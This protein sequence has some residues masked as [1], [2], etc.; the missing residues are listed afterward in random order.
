MLTLKCPEHV[1]WPSNLNVCMVKKNTMSRTYSDTIDRI[2]E[3]VF[4]GKLCSIIKK[5]NEFFLLII[6]TNENNQKCET[7]TR[8]PFSMNKA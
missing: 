3:D 6:K 5:C 8:T 1:N 4:H 7:R 2:Q